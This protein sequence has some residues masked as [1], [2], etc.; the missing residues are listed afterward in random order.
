MTDA[1]MLEELAQLREYKR[2]HEEIKEHQRRQREYNER[3]P[4]Q[5]SFCGKAREEVQRLIH[6]PRVQI[7]DECVGLCGEICNGG[8]A[9]SGT[10]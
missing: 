3:H 2:I 7:C 8:N 6:G 9:P 4:V 1:A 10:V 5:C